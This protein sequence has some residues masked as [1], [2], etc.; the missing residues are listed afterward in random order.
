[1]GF[2]IG[3]FLTLT[4]AMILSSARA[5]AQTQEPQPL[6]GQWRGD[7]TETGDGETIHYRMF[8]S[9]DADRN[10]RPVGS[11]SYNLE[12][13]GI[14][15]GAERRGRAWHFDETITAGRTNCASHVDAE[16]A[17]EGDGL[18]VRLHPVDAPEQ[19]AQGVLRPSP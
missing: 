12:C 3:T 5:S 8:V 6:I 14:W 1:M 7:V 19:I 17:R 13:R 2:G 9:I 4:A 16:I 18:R 15:T 10:G 11:V